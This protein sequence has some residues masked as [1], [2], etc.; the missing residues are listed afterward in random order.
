MANARQ[1]RARGKVILLGEHTVVYGGPAIALAL[2]RGAR[3]EACPAPATRLSLA[4]KSYDLPVEAVAGE[5]DVLRAFRALLASLGSGCVEASAELEV[6]A[7]AGLGASA[8]LGVALARAVAG[9]REAESN[10]SIARAALAWENVFHGNAS[11]L[12]TAVAQHAGCIWFTRASGVLTL[13]LTRPLHVMVAV[14]EPGA[15]TRRMVEGVAALRLAEPGRVE[16]CSSEI[17]RLVE[18]ARVA[19]ERGEMSALGPLLQHNHELL[20]ELGVST[21]GLDRACECATS[22][23][24]LGAKLTGAGGGGSVIA[25]AEGDACERVRAAWLSRGFQCLEARSG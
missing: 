21:A 15:S 24:A 11:G 22:A 18:Q 10:G 8:A 3:A 12:D 7:G 4:G 13:S 6:P 23:G 9:S 5:P 2:D 1:A 14:V 20:R 25:L 17:S 16:R 19:L